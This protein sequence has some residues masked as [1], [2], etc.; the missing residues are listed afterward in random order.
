METI[1]YTMANISKMYKYQTF[2][3]MKMHNMR[4]IW[5]ANNKFS[6]CKVWVYD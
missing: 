5:F 1:F 6:L 4:K 3:W 2:G